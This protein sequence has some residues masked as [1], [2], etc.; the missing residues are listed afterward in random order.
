LEKSRSSSPPGTASTAACRRD[1]VKWS[2]RTGMSS[3]R[4]TMTCDPGARTCRVPLGETISTSMKSVSET[5]T[6]VAIALERLLESRRGVGRRALDHRRGDEQNALGV[7]VAAGLG[8]K[9]ITK[10]RNLHQQ[11]DAGPVQGGGALLK[12]AEHDRLAHLDVHVGA[13][14]GE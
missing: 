11:R 2:S 8:A 1:T 6:I 10:H 4:P 13:R 5:A 3:A 7:G 9:Q 12:A 14:L